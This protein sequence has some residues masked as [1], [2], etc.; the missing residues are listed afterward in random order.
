M[1]HDRLL[2]AR[3]LAVAGE[4][5]AI[6][7]LPRMSRQV[8]RA[9]AGRKAGGS[10]HARRC[11]A[12]HEESPAIDLAERAEIPSWHARFR[13]ARNAVLSLHLMVLPGQHGYD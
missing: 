2:E 12:A 11:R 3:R 4:A 13:F 9:R 8:L 10:S 5:R 6:D 1:P 7:A